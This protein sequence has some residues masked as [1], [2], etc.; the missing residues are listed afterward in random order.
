M[1]IKLNQILKKVT[2]PHIVTLFLLVAILVYGN[3]VFNKFVTDDFSYILYQNQSVN[4]AGWFGQ[5]V[6]NTMG[7]YRPIPTAYFSILHILFNTN[8]LPYH[9]LQIL[10]HVICA[11]LLYVLF[12]KFLSAGISLF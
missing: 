5:N 9:V 4:I 10:L 1:E 8:A 2:L 11:A 7:Q 12:R 6:F 3:V